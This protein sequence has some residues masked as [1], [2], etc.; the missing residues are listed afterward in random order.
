MNG[1]GTE[2]AYPLALSLHELKPLRLDD[3]TQ[4]FQEENAAEQGQQQLL[5]D[6][7]GTYADDAANHQ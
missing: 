5:V 6:D 3:Y 1:S 7:D 2:D 4:T